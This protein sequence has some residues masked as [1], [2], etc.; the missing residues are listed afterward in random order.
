[1][2]IMSET[3]T[4]SAKVDS[5]V[6]DSEDHYLRH[7]TDEETPF[8]G[9]HHRHVTT[10][11]TDEGFIVHNIIESA[12]SEAAP[13]SLNWRQTI[14]AG[15]CKFCDSELETDQTTTDD[16]RVYT[17]T[18]PTCPFSVRMAEVS[19]DYGSRWDKTPQFYRATIPHNF[20][21]DPDVDWSDIRANKKATAEVSDLANLMRALYLE[22]YLGRIRDKAYDSDTREIST[23]ECGS[24]GD[25]VETPAAREHPYFGMVC[26][27]CDGETVWTIE[28]ADLPE[29]VRQ[30][31]D[32]HASFSRASVRRL[33]HEVRYNAEYKRTRARKADADADEIQ[34]IPD[35]IKTGTG[36]EIDAQGLGR[37][38]PGT[39]LRSPG[40]VFHDNPH[41]RTLLGDAIETGLIEQS[42]P[43]VDPE[44]SS[45]RWT[46][47]DKGADVLAELNHCETCG[48]ALKPYLRMSIYK[49][50]PTAK[51]L[52]SSRLTSA[53]P[54]CDVS[55]SS[56]GA[57][58]TLS[59]S[60]QSKL[61]TLD[62]I[63]YE[64]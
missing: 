31:M 40:S 55:P 8:S 28:D 10:R 60:S 36:G 38:S 51:S 61:L 11:V 50:S 44:E 39:G 29:D 53:C 43:S 49:N 7:V 15:S 30:K 35:G 20:S 14:P 56:N 21:N 26:P 24:C 57:A 23:V 47:T 13:E 12:D 62:G 33:L 46:L 22:S 9:R 45:A 42:N 4:L 2:P 16:R 59:S 48:G 17:S 52:R 58:L 34:N 25:T 64:N 41:W 54:T 63:D 3:P 37:G 32:K 19:A 18:C 5:H 27:D 1:M 6:G